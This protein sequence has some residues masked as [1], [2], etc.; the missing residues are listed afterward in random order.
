MTCKLQNGYTSAKIS[1]HRQ[2]FS[3]TKKYYFWSPRH[4]SEGVVF[5]GQTNLAI[6]IIH[7]VYALKF[8]HD[9]FLW[10]L[11]YYMTFDTDFLTFFEKIIEGSKR[12]FNSGISIFETILGLHWQDSFRSKGCH[13]L[14]IKSPPIFEWDHLV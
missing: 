14:K 4:T 2:W 7:S 13:Y 12:M 5:I 11:Q 10:W 1:N 6:N 3:L 8:C 9:D